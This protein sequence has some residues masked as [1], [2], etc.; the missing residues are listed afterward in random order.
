M[1]DL[2]HLLLCRLLKRVIWVCMF[3]WLLFLF[4]K[5][6]LQREQNIQGLLYP[7]LRWLRAFYK[8][9]TFYCGNVCEPRIKDKTVWT[10]SLAC[11]KI[12]E[13]RKITSFLTTKS[14]NHPQSILVVVSRFVANG[15]AEAWF[16][17][18][19]I[20]GGDERDFGIKHLFLPGSCWWE[21]MFGNAT[22][23]KRNSS[24]PK[25]TWMFGK[26]QNISAGLPE[27]FRNRASF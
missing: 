26:Q 20:G 7:E 19:E 1:C 10:R 2:F 14:V 27:Q 11:C 6:C 9:V 15:I 13:I 17:C 3:R 5:C 8:N 12:Q 24:L 18:C 21:V 16:S 25:I 22:Q 4:L 23:I